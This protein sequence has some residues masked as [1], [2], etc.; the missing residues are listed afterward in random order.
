MHK[1]ISESRPKNKTASSARITPQGRVPR[2][3]KRQKTAGR[4]VRSDWCLN[5]A[6]EKVRPKLTRLSDVEAKPVQWLWKN[7]I[8]RGN[9][10]MIVGLGSGGKTFQ[11]IDMT[12]HITKGTDWADGTPCDKGSVLFFYGEDGL[13]TYK[14]RC[15]VNGVDLKR[16]VFMEGTEVFKDQ[17]STEAGVT[18]SDIEVIR[19][20]IHN[21][22]EMTGLPVKAVFIDPITNYLG[23][24]SGNSASG[25]RSVLHPL[26]RLAEEL[27]V[28]IVMIHHFAKGRKA[29]LQQQ[30]SGSGALVECCRAVWGIFHDPVEN[31]RYFAP[32]KFNCGAD[33]TAISF[34]IIA[35]SGKVKVL[36]TDIQRSA[37]EIAD[38]ITAAKKLATGRPPKA[39][40]EVSDWLSDTLGDGEKSVKEIYAAAKAL[41]YSERTVNRAK[42]ALGI[43]S[44]KCGFGKGSYFVWM[45]PSSK[46]G[47][48][49][50]TTKVL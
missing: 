46:G 20:A 4:Q 2:A 43:K 29:H 48:N 33:P 49:S 34:Q 39:L 24:V 28:A 36:E 40:T 38:G 10:S 19:Q 6:G 8:P 50:K 15:K 27:D 25:V 37:E 17:E 1:S 30:I 11:T 7:K 5:Q 42:E 14:E 47:Q 3:S 44:S 31:L 32:V 22:E 9:L 26:Q 23:K 16:V 18:V 13:D 41:G 12:A 21:T 35:P 45:L